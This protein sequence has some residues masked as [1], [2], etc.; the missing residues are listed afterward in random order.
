MN[1]IDTGASGR[2]NSTDGVKNAPKSRKEISSKPGGENN[3]ARKD[4]FETR[5]QNERSYAVRNDGYGNHR[6]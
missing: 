2:L 4:T 6:R 1:T 5:G 3:A